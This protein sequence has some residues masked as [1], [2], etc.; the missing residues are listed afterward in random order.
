[1]ITHLLRRNATPTLISTLSTGPMQIER[2]MAQVGA[3]ENRTLAP[4]QQY[5]NRGFISGG[6]LALAS[7]AN[8]PGTASAAGLQ[9]IGDLSAYRMVIVA[10]AD[11]DR[12]RSWIEQIAGALGSTPLVMILSE[13]AEPMVRP[14]YDAATGPVRG[15]LTGL[16]GALVYETNTAQQGGAGRDW[17]PFNVGL[18]I[19]VTLMLL[20]ALF[21][22]LS[23]RLAR[24]KVTAEVK[25]S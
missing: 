25:D 19:A 14:Y 11:P 6:P 10:T 22:I 5:V 2:L 12:A 24:R 21:N 3:A 16:T 9:G 1:V 20:G 8:R 13:Q 18:V 17:A 4:G 7:L 15:M 23:G